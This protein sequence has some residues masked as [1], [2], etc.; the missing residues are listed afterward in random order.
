M[1]QPLNRSAQAVAS[2]A[3]TA[4]FTFDSVPQGQQWQGTVAISG[5]PS[6]AT[7][8]ATVAD[9]N[10]GV[11][12]GPQ[13]FGP[14]QIDGRLSLSIAGSFLVPGQTYVAVLQGVA[15]SAG[16][17]PPL[18]PQPSPL[19][20]FARAPLFDTRFNGTAAIAFV[21]TLIPA[22]PGF[23]T[24]CDVSNYAGVRCSFFNTGT[25]AVQI[26]ILFLDTHMQQ[27]LGIH[28]VFLA[29]SGTANYVAKGAN[30]LIPC[31]GERLQIVINSAP[32]GS[33]CQ[34]D[35]RVSGVNT[36]RASFVPANTGASNGIM[37]DA[38]A[39]INNVTVTTLTSTAAPANYVYAGPCTLQLSFSAAPSTWVA[40]VAC[41][42]V[43][44][45]DF[46][47][48]SYDQISA[49]GATLRPRPLGPFFAP[50]SPL[51]IIFTNQG[52]GSTIVNALLV[53]DDWR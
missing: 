26:Q 30:F 1:Q 38:L 40:S 44:G 27:T 29:G 12:S 6:Y 3:G 36:D 47:V 43:S 20:T 4:T 23:A 10:W 39:A 24:T 9:I 31:L 41:L 52:S 25:T 7:F 13:S 22:A 35:V 18:A 45:A 37:D 11:F 49:P 5:A 46:T 51:R 8:Q 48:A 14:V 16:E 19:P 50:P 53:A 42:T 34:V 2:A 21:P 15:A 17:L 33:S 28:T 32:T